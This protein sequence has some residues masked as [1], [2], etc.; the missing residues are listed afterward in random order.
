[1]GKKT[2]DIKE[3]AKLGRLEHD[4]DT[5]QEVD[6]VID[7]DDYELDVLD[8]MGTVYAEFNDDGEY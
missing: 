2:K 6:I 7:D 8:T 5:F 1:M 4:I 3:A